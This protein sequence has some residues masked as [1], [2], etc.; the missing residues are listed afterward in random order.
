MDERIKKVLLWAA[1]VVL[2]V[3]VGVYIINL[4]RGS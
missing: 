4:G 3:V 2:A 1:L